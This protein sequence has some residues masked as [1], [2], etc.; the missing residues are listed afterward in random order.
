MDREEELRALSS[1]SPPSFAVVYGRRRVG[2][3]RLLREWI[4]NKKAVYYYSQLATHETN[5]NELARKASKELGDPM[6]A[7]LKFESLRDLL[8][9]IA[10]RMGD[11][12][13]VIDELGFWIRGD[14][15]V[16]SELQEFVDLVLPK[17]NVILVVTSS[18][19]SVFVRGVLGG[20]SPLYARTSLRLH[21]KP[22]SFEHLKE[23]MPSWKAEER[24]KLYSMVG[25]IPYYLCLA[26]RSLEETLEY[27]LGLG[28]PLRDEKDLLLSEEFRDPSSYSSVLSA[29]AKG[30]RRIT[31]IS[32][33]TGLDKG[34]VSKIL[35]TLET[36]GYVRK[37]KVLFT[38][39]SLY[40]VADPVL[41]FWYSCIEENL[42]L[43]ELNF[44]EGL[45]EVS[46]CLEVL[47]PKVWEE[48]VGEWVVKN[49]SKLGFSEV[50]RA[51]KGREELDV[52]ALNEKEKR[53]LVVEVKWSE[54]SDSEYEKVKKNTL[55][56]AALIVP[57]KYEVEVMI[58]CLNNEKCLKPEDVESSS[59]QFNPFEPH[60]KGL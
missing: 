60:A 16:L 23:F 34:H 26:R 47:V 38:K 9:L 21:L 31:E 46:R 37:E 3:T 22:L 27:F 58:A 2:K 44:G 48:V 39:R 56:K 41:R 35:N 18:L 7:R 6:L 36:L 4:G 28:G 24:L 11:G 12:I 15:R 50:G 55:R 49:Y 1:L 51:I 25:G 42:E 57:R 54:L 33:V 59:Q 40:E 5:L 53:A 32:Q 52:V 13:I 17:T 29:L 8:E 43:L 30:Y 14:S 20:G 45:K 19:M 10:L